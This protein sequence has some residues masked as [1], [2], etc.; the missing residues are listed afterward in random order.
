MKKGTKI[1]LIVVAVYVK[2]VVEVNKEEKDILK[3][4]Q[5]IVNKFK[6]DYYKYMNR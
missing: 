6:Q 1:A 4:K 2:C 3:M 5:K